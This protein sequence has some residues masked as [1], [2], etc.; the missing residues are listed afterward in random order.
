MSKVVLPPSQGHAAFTR[1]DL[2]PGTLDLGRRAGYTLI[3]LLLVLAII[4]VAAAAVTPSLRGVLRNAGLKAAANTVRAELTRAHVTAMKTGRTQV[5]QYELG[6]GKYKIQPWIGDD[7]A[8]ESP[9]GDTSSAPVPSPP[10]H[11][12]A[13]DKTLSEGT[14]FTAGDALVESR[15]QRID[16]ELS[17]SGGSGATW[18][19]PILFY[20]DGSASDAFIIVGND[21]QAGIRIDLRGM[22]GAVKIGELSDLHKLEQDAAAPR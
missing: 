13:A 8:L 5:F 4:V 10:A 17:G 15:S 3:E 11:S 14:K 6:G 1:I 20:R 22:T 16:E 18:S 21:H 2:G 19:R 7:D 9:T 12:A